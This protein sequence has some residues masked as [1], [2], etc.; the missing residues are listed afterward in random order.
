MDERLEEEKLKNRRNTGKYVTLN[1]GQKPKKDYSLIKDIREQKLIKANIEVRDKVAR[2]YLTEN[3]E[4]KGPNSVLPGQLVMFNYFNPITKEDLEYYDAMPVT[5]FFGIHKTEKGKRII[6]FN[7]HYYPPRIRYEVM[8]R[9]FEIYKPFYLK[10]FNSPI[11]SEMDHFEY[12]WLMK[13]LEKAKLDFGVRQ[14]D[15]SLCGK[16]IPLPTEA[17]AKAVFTEGH[18]K[19]STREKIMQ[20]WKNKTIKQ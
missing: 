2:K 10:S 8:N 20:Y 5:I 11:K 6:G 4:T 16:I 3:Y 13:Q 18:F 12:Q 15:P 1:K 17:W 19:K 7:I 14:Y 9:I